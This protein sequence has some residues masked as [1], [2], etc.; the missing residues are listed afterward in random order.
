MALPQ[1]MA[2]RPFLE[3]LEPRPEI[4]GTTVSSLSPNTTYHFQIVAYSS[5]GNDYGGDLTF[6]TTALAKSAN[7]VRL[8]RLVVSPVSAPN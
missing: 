3:T 2:A 7:G 5:G 6:T 4:Y 8:W 1:L